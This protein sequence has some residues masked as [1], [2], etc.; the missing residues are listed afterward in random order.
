VTAFSGSTRNASYI[1]SIVPKCQFLRIA[2]FEFCHIRSRPRPRK[3]E[4]VFGRINRH[5]RGRG[6]ASN[7]LLCESAIATA[8]IEPSKALW[9]VEPVEE[10]FAYK[11]APTA[12]H[13]LIG[14]SVS[15]KLYFFHLHSPCV[16]SQGHFAAFCVGKL[17]A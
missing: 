14:L 12:H 3:G 11:A 15:E 9:N 6:R 5:H 7:N 2:H 1:E 4:L 8:D 10:R 16:I 13:P 17:I